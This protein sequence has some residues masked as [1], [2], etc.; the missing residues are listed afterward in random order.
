MSGG[1]SM[2]RG[3]QGLN[4]MRLP[5][6]NIDMTIFRSRYVI[7]GSVEIKHGEK[8]QANKNLIAKH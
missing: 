6:Y 3:V 7:A 4:A 5:H 1:T 8:E 2:F